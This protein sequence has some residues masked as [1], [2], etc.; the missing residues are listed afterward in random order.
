M[1]SEMDSEKVLQIVRARK[2]LYE[3]K[4]ERADPLREDNYN[5]HDLFKHS[6]E[7]MEHLEAE[8]TAALQQEKVD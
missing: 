2:A 6:A 1:E 5:R 7:A 8:L 4:A 3:T